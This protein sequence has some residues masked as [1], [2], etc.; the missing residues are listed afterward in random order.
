MAS[1][2]S[3]ASAQGA[4]PAELTS[5]VGRRRELTETRRLLASSRLLTL[6]GVGGV[7]KTRLAMRMAAEVRRTFPDGVWFVELAALRDPQLLPHTVANALELRQVSAD[8]TADL[9]AYLEQQRLLVVLDNCEH[10][11]DACA[12]LVSKVLAAAPGLRILATSRHVLGVEG[13][14][15]LSVPPL[16]T[17]DMDREVSAGDATHYES[18]TLFLDRAA[19]VAPGFEIGDSN[20]APVIEVCRRLDGIPLAIELAAVWLRVLSPAQIL[21]RLEDRFRL[22]TSSRRAGPPHQQ[23]LAATVGWSFD[24][25]SPAEQLMWARLSVFSGGFDLEAAEEVCCGDGIPREDVLNLIAG[26]VNKSIVM[27]HHATEH[28]TAWYRMLESIRQYGAERLAAQDQVRALQ[29][30]HRDH[31]RSVAKRFEAEGFG[32][33]QA[34]WFIRLRRES[35]NLRAALEFCLSE[36]GEAAAALD[37]AAPIWNFWF[38]GFLREGYRYLTRALDLAREPTSGRAHGLWAASYLAMFATEFEQNATMLAECTEIAAGLDDD[39]LQARIKECRGQAT[40]YQGD[41]PGAIEWLEQARRQFRA[42]GDPLGEF[43]TLILLTACT[44][45]LDD[46]RADEF[47]RQALA[48]AEHH[49]AQSSMAYGHW[50][51]GIA[52]WRA[53]DYGQA[54]RSLRK[55]VRLFQPMHD[56]TGISFG[57]QALSWCAAFAEPGEEAARLLGAAQAVWR[58]SGAKVD[59]T[60]AYS[61]FD[62][63]SEDALREALGSAVLESE[64]FE[65][66]FAEGAA[67]SFDQAVALALGETDMDP[68]ESGRTGAFSQLTGNPGGLTRRELEISKLLAEGL[69]N[70]G[71][72]VRLVISQR[73]VETHVDRILSKLGFTSRLQVASWVAEQQAR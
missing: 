28:L 23:A 16:S 11:T 22:L 24:L 63:R 72:A 2:K 14:Q 42:L 33:Q 49:G 12:V 43:D 26:L 17:P 34:D 73:T 27:R 64:A 30:R 20:R 57:V 1:T 38:A 48:L 36:R 55:S 47:S 32:P 35:G 8:P 67:Y 56:L 4:L 37:I 39:L 52:Q 25:C 45:F 40:L 68:A 21:D 15:I 9:S 66:A 51:V 61:V 29:V 19:A 71:I 7:G 44:F 18:V 3:M 60:N 10:L 62:K 53:G 5:F 58:T 65:T 69:S 13:E 41:L 70:K 46:P 50:S 54:T 59:E 31:Y 6:T